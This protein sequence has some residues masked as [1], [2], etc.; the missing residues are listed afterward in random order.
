MIAIDVDPE[1]LAAL[2]EQTARSD[3]FEEA[4]NWRRPSSVG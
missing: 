3:L 2:T 4:R 1:R